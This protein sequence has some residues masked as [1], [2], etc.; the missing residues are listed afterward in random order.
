MITNN[1]NTAD[2]NDNHD[3]DKMIGERL[4]RFSNN[5]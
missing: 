5:F 2:Q 1:K 3:T 4:V